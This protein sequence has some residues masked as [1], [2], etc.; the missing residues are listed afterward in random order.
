MRWIQPTFI[1]ALFL[2]PATGLRADKKNPTFADDV[3]PVIKQHC[4][5][6]HS[7]DKQKGGLN[8]ASFPATMQGGSSGVV[9]AAGDPDKSRIYTLSA[10]KEEPVM[11]PS[12][13][14]IP[15]DQLEVLR[16]WV[17]QGARETAMSKAAMPVKPK[18]DIG[19]KSVGKGKPEG[20]PPMPT[21]GKFKVDPFVV[22]RR[23]GAV[24]GLA[25]SPWAPLVAVGGQKQ[26]LLF[27]ADHGDLLGVLPFEHGQI[28]SIRFSRNAKFLLVAG[29][30]GGASG[31]AVLFNVETGEKVTEVGSAETDAILSADISADQSLIAVGT[32]TRL[33]R[34]YSVAD[35]S[36][37]QTIKKHTDW[38]TAVE[39]SPDG[40]L[41]A[42]GDRN[43]GVFVWEAA[44]A[45]EFHTIRG[46]TQMIT[47]VSW[48]ADSNLLATGSLDGTIRLWE[49]ENGGQVK[50]WNAHGGG[51][52]AVR[53]SM[54]GR[55]A[56]TG[57]DKLT[58][59]WDGNGALQKQFET[60]AEVGLR[61]GVSHDNTKVIGGDWSGALRVW[62]TADGR[63]LATMTTNPGPRAEQVKEAEAALIAVTAKIKAIG[64]AYIA[65]QAKAKQSGDAFAAAQANIAKLN[66]DLA[67]NQKTF[68]EK[69]AAATALT[70]QVP[71]AKAEADKQTAAL[72]AVNNKAFALETSLPIYAETAKKLQ[73]AA[74]KAPQN[75][76]LAAAAKPAADAVVKLQADLVVVKK[77]Q[78][79]TAAAHKLA[80]DKSAKLTVD[81][82][83]AQAAAVEA[84]KIVDALPPAI[85]AAADGLP[86]VKKAADDA[87]AAS[88]VVKAQADMAA[89]ELKDAQAKFER[90]K[91]TP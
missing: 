59:L 47:D 62:S 21:A 25:A 61:V 60:F 4:I 63:K 76:D 78:A 9:V 84:K 14:K 53:F 23:P 15:A 27:H 89:A 34:I 81:L 12:K 40:V 48:R 87:A 74:A 88:N 43:G 52:E 16:L 54:D 83:A 2:L 30:R 50:N 20:L 41:L 46:H 70:P 10:H 28:Q 67:L 75:P 71:P 11:P 69:T 17:E 8:L 51:V 45:R 56:S 7:D 26:V 3:L 85:K 58:K 91:K 73:E 5:N 86:A 65:A 37:Q 90:L 31:K 22:A 33:V 32:T 55:L 64:D 44:T 29:G 35:G 39:F 68:T 79:E 72:A 80:V 49:M 6:C 1:S 24:L 82:A 38:V 57:R 42:S 19:L 66:G 13:Q 18:V 36:V 77:A